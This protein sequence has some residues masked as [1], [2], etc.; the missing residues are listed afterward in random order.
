MGSSQSERNLW[1]DGT[2]WAL[3]S[4]WYVFLVTLLASYLYPSTN[5]LSTSGPHKLNELSSRSH[6]IFIIICEKSET[7]HTNNIQ[8][9]KSKSSV[10]YV[11]IFVEISNFE[12]SSEFCILKQ[13]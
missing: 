6:A 1:S 11:S 12:I 4:D 10:R 7:Y 3:P 9:E 5:H 13:M 2:R 8:T